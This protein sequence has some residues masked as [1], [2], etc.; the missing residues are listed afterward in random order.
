MFQQ[1]TNT[2]YVWNDLLDIQKSPFMALHKVGVEV[3]M[4]ENQNDFQKNLSYQINQNLTNGFWYA[5]RSPIM[6]WCKVREAGFVMDQCGWIPNCPTTF[7]E[8]FRC[9]ISTKPAS[10]LEAR[11]SPSLMASHTAGSVFGQYGR[12]LELLD[13]TGSLRH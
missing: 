10:L 13:L 5:W 8:N 4:A 3:D 11:K 9:L 7:N 12:S 2:Q 1:H 6:V